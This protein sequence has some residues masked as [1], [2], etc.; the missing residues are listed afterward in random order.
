MEID[1]TKTL[2]VDLPALRAAFEPVGAQL[3]AEWTIHATH[4][5]M[6]T[7]LMVSKLGHCLADL[8]W[9]WRSLVNWTARSRASSRITRTCVR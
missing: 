2:S 4:A 7:V 6:K 1:V 8:L 9:R 5:R 3:Q